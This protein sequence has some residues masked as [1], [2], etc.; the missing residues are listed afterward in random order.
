MDN[1]VTAAD[2]F[3]RTGHNDGNDNDSLS[4]LSADLWH[5]IQQASEQVQ[6]AIKTV[7]GSETLKRIVDSVSHAAA[8]AVAPKEADWTIAIDFT[9]DFGDG[10]GVYSG[11]ENLHDFAKH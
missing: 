10:Q 5:E 7:A 4:K 6:S 2:R 3:S 9:T 11:L 8:A 1:L